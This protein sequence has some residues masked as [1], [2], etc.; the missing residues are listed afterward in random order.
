M[1]DARKRL[2]DKIANA[3]ATITGEKNY[4]RVA[5]VMSLLDCFLALPEA[6][7]ELVDRP[8]VSGAQASALNAMTPIG[9][10]ERY[11]ALDKYFAK[12]GGAIANTPE[13]VLADTADAWKER[14]LAAEREVER[15]HAAREEERTLH[16]TTLH[17]F[18]AYK[19]AARKLLVAAKATATN[20]INHGALKSAVK[21]LEK[22]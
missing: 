16:N 5:E 13:T 11:P 9:P 18:A 22:L 17:E 1:T 4:G 10:T 15:L 19:G 12:Q 2:E 6:L 8:A 7:A 3:K 21:A 20:D 14:A